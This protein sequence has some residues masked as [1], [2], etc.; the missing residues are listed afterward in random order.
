MLDRDPPHVLREVR[1]TPKTDFLVLAAILVTIVVP[2]ALTLAVVA[3]PR[4]MVAVA[5]NPS[6]FGYTVSLLNFL[7]PTVVLLVWFYRNPRYH[8]HRKSF[9]RALLLLTSLGVILDLVFGNLF[10]T[11]P[12]VAATVGVTVPGIGGRVPIEEFG[13]YSLGFSSIL[14]TYIWSAEYWLGA[15]SMPDHV[16]HARET[17]R[18]VRFHWPSL[19]VGAVLLAAAYAY[20]KLAPDADHNGF[21]GYFAFLLAIG[22]VPSMA[23]L[24]TVRPFINWRALSFTVALMLLVSLLWEATLGVPYQWW[25]Y[26]SEQMIGIRIDAWS[27]LPVEEPILWTIVSYAGVIFYEVLRILFAKRHAGTSPRSPQGT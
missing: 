16:E 8:L 21:P 27:N 3:H 5:G 9:V 2:A 22:I 25:G 12:N 10:F 11:F 23:F 18:L 14:L 20:K 26:K 13:F 1:R 15:Y 24:H 4:P 7:V 17:K 6:P 19:I